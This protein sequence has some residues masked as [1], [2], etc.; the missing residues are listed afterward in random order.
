[1][2][3]VYIVPTQ[4]SGED[5]E[6]QNVNWKAGRNDVVFTLN[7]GSQDIVDFPATYNSESDAY[8]AVLN[9]ENPHV[10]GSISFDQSLNA[11]GFFATIDGSINPVVNGP[12]SLWYPA[13]S[14]DPDD[15]D[16][17]PDNIKDHTAS[18]NQVIEA[19]RPAQVRSQVNWMD[20]VEEIVTDILNF[21][22]LDYRVRSIEKYLDEM[23]GRHNL[24]PIIRINKDIEKPE[25][26]SDDNTEDLPD[27][28]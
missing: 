14:V 2:S 15:P 9:E 23:D 1:M 22:P 21:V 3:K 10:I 18:K 24:D 11:Y 16:K 17:K 13:G 28:A 5:G 4:T 26:N 27:E 8:F 19:A 7:A 6:L 25:D 20:R 12:V